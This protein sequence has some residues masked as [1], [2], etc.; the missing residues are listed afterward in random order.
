M[1]Y[2]AILFDMN[3]VLVNDE[4]LQEKAFQQTLSRF[5]IPLTSRD[6]IRFF[7][8]KTDHKGFADYFKALNLTHDID[9][10]IAQ[11]GKEYEKLARDGVQSYP[12][13]REFIEAAFKQGF[14]LAVVTSSMNNEAVSVLTGLKLTS[15]FDTIVAADNIKN[16]K[17]DPEGYL[18]G[19]ASLSV[20]PQECI[21]IEDSPSGL[22][23]AKA[24]G[25]F[26]IAVLNTHSADELSEASITIKDLSA[27]LLSTLAEL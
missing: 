27:T 16:G 12:M 6:Y 19:A 14:T 9:S 5:N 25:M 24:A 4:H 20:L 23:A 26:S 2:R 22:K 15:Y 8:G 1:N 17:P 10:L 21:V 11:K 18:K 3:G 13:V 7:I